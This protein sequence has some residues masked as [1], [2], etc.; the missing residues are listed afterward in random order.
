MQYQLLPENVIVELYNNGISIKQLE[1]IY[2]NNEARS[3]LATSQFSQMSPEEIRDYLSGTALL[4]QNVKKADKGIHFVIL[5]E[6]EP[7]WNLYKNHFSKIVDAAIPFMNQE[8]FSEDS[9]FPRVKALHSIAAY[10]S[11]Y[12]QHCHFILRE[13]NRLSQIHPAVLEQLVHIH[14]EDLHTFITHA[15]RLAEGLRQIEYLYTLHLFGQLSREKR[16]TVMDQFNPTMSLRDRLDL[17]VNA[18]Q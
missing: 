18:K 2:D 14:P 10:V 12:P 15:L 4:A 3:Y 1:D 7:H 11:T 6:L 8:Q 16:Q 9:H 5:C 13:L 17:V